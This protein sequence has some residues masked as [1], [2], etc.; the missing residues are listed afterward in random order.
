VICNEIAL[1]A[2]PND[3]KQA[4]P[5][6]SRKHGVTVF[7]QKVNPILR[8]NGVEGPFMAPSTRE[9]VAIASRRIVDL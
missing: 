2:A 8:R 7:H 5:L 9:Y 3:W 6:F 1:K 4:R